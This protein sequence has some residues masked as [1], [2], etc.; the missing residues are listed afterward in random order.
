M[1][2]A[3]DRSD[4][5]R[6]LHVEVRNND[7]YENSRSRINRLEFLVSRFQRA[8]STH[9]I[10]VHVRSL[11]NFEHESCEQFHD[12]FGHKHITWS[13]SVDIRISISNDQSHS[14]FIFKGAENQKG[15]YE[16]HLMIT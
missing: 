4:F 14:L 7:P 2:R 5:D 8:R 6:S 13:T 12:H 16:S 1:K 10:G 3:A 15:T 9:F 11:T